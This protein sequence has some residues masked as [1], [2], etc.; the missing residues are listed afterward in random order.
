MM[1]FPDSFKLVC[2]VFFP[3]GALLDTH[4]VMEQDYAKGI[5]KLANKE[6]EAENKQ[7]TAER[8]TI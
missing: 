3:S 8:K 2:D 7:T 6:H 5:F 4:G 1:D